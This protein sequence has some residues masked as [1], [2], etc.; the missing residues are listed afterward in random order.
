MMIIFH[1]IFKI[2]KNPIVKIE[3]NRIFKNVVTCTRCIILQNRLHVDA[4]L[5]LK[6]I[7]VNGALKDIYVLSNYACFNQNISIL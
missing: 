2:L 5:F 1:F 4:I 6:K 3:L 7:Q